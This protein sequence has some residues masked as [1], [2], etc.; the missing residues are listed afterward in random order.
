[1]RKE[2]TGIEETTLREVMA[3]VL[4]DLQDIRRFIEVQQKA[5][6]ANQQLANEAIQNLKNIKFT[7]PH[8]DISKVAE[9]VD[10]GLSQ[11]QEKIDKGPKA[12]KRHYRLLLFPETNTERYYKLVFGGLIPW[13]FAFIIVYYLIS[14]A[15]N[16]IEAWQQHDY[17]QQNE[18]VAK[19]WVYLY[20]HSNSQVK[21]A[22]GNAVKKT[23]DY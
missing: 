7:T 20:G 17:N 18:Q 2:Q 5:V 23:E 11:I 10:K 15:N 8:P 9:L 21:K 13:G 16:S 22:M 14:L 1:M 19:A 3:D 6:E 12:I 4:N